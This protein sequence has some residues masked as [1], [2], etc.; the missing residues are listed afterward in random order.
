MPYEHSY[1]DIYNCHVPHNLKNDYGESIYDWLENARR[2]YVS[3]AT[4]LTEEQ[5]KC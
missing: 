5:K 3:D 4:R 2:Y 1:I